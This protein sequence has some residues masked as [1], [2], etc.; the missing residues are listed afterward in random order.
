MKRH[1]FLALIASALLS[2]RAARAQSD[3]APPV[4]AEPPPLPP[5][6]EPRPAPVAPVATEEWPVAPTTMKRVPF[7]S[8]GQWIIHSGSTLNVSHS[9]FDNFGNSVT[10]VTVS[11]SIDY[12]AAKR[13]SIG[14]DLDIGYQHGGAA[15]PTVFKSTRFGAGLRVGY[16]IPLG[17]R[18][19]LYPRL[20]FGFRE[21][22][23]S[24]VETFSSPEQTD[25][26]TAVVATLFV[27]LL[28]HV[29]P[30]FFV[31]LGP[32]FSH[33]FEDKSTDTTEVYGRF[34]V[35]MVLGG[36][37]QP[38]DLE[39]SARFGDRG[40]WVFTGAEESEISHTETGGA[41]STAIALRP[42]V[43]T[44][45]ARNLS[46]GAFLDYLQTSNASTTNRQLA[47][48]PRIGYDLRL[49]KHVSIWPRADIAF[50]R[51]TSERSQAPIP[52]LNVNAPASTDSHATAVS[53]GL[54]VPVL[55]HVATHAFLGLGPYLRRDL[56]R[57]YDGGT[58]G[59]DRFTRY[60][61]ELLVGGWL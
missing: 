2:S 60:G 44:F 34:L 38:D 41:S 5:A 3:D 37:E 26:S 31:G 36:P 8:P 45:V 4:G 13:F 54:D 27:P 23:V 61:V 46:V 22:W 18:L 52:S 42:G 28:F 10:S 57:H 29:A 53:F 49:G 58:G 16:A 25:K 48:G 19:S 51:V 9:A 20:T 14:A 15:D 24:R 59:G 7:G 33:S 40:T 55:L 47:G 50:A 17:E 43:D 32:G 56:Y 6:V 21:T 30:R 12:F 1:M 35:G 39:P 11:P